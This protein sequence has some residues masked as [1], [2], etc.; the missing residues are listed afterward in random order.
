MA[1][2]RESRKTAVFPIAVAAGPAGGDV[3][4]SSAPSAEGVWRP[5]ICS[6]RRCSRCR[7][8]PAWI[9]PSPSPKN[10]GQ[11][12]DHQRQVLRL[13]GFQSGGP[14][15]GGYQERPDGERGLVQQGAPPVVGGD[16]AGDGVL[17]LPRLAEATAYQARQH[18][19]IRDTPEQG[20]IFMFN[21]FYKEKLK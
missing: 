17:D 13:P 11:N 6:P 19:E 14:E 1:A 3:I 18:G 4:G 9:P 21:H 12:V 10:A 5:P 8:R 2:G 16:T 7:R 15:L 20:P